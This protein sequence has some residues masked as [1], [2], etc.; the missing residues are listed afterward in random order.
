MMNDLISDG[1]G[2][3]R[4][5]VLTWW[6]RLLYL[7]GGYQSYRRVDWEAVDRLVFVCKGNICR[8]AY[9]EAVAKSL[10]AESLSCGIDTSTGGRAD[11]N[12]MRA[13]VLRGVD[14]EQHRTTPIQSLA[15][16]KGDLL[17]VMEPGQAKR[18]E[19]EPG[20]NNQCTLIGLWGGAARPYIHDP[21]GSSA[22]YFNN[23]FYYI[24]KSVHGI[25][26]EI[27]QKKR[28]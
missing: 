22:E 27:Q 21:Y 1:Y 5:M 18:L 16:R 2:S 25:V 4:G 7:F 19:Q 17:V 20:W 24:E 9:A 23:C 8:S 13:A 11:G 15:I 3:K 28:Y 14:L 10:G 12:A 26:K 6:H